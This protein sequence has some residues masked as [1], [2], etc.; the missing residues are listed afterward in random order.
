MAWGSQSKRGGI[1]HHIDEDH[2]NN[3][4]INLAVGHSACHGQHHAT[5]RV[6]SEEARA[7][8]AARRRERLPCP[9]CGREF[10]DTWMVRHRNLGR[11][12]NPTPEQIEA[13]RIER[14]E[15]STRSR[16]QMTGR[17]WTK[18]ALEKR[19]ATNTG[20]KWS[21]AERASRAARRSAGGP[22]PGPPDGW[23]HTP[24]ARRAISEALKRRRSS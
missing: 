4:I 22:R 18:E 20:R 14:E 21:E 15:Q 5:G 24:E 7:K 10:N 13:G 8:M 6:R 16:R 1:I 12:V 23:K 2:T 17:T 3:A 19:S 9:D 11:C